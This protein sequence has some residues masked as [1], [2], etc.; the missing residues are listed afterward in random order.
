MIRAGCLAEAQELDEKLFSSWADNCLMQAE[1]ALQGGLRYTQ[2]AL[3]QLDDLALALEAGQDKSPLL[4]VFKRAVELLYH[5]VDTGSQF[6]QE[7]M[8][9][10]F[11]QRRNMTTAQHLNKRVEMHEEQ[12]VYSARSTGLVDPSERELQ[13]VD[14]LEEVSWR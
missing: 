6:K 12:A 8:I 11:V 9:Q 2:S 13:R 4:V 7:T 5:Q 14:Q 3:K 1:S 10:A